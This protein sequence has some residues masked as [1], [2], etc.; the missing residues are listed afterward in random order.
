VAAVGSRQVANVVSEDLLMLTMFQYCLIYILCALL[1]GWVL[2]TASERNRRMV[3]VAVLA[4]VVVLLPLALLDYTSQA[5][6][7][8]PLHTYLLISTFPAVGSATVLSYLPQSGPS[9]VSR[10]LLSS[11]VWLV[12]VFAT[13]FTGFYP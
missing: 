4:C 8:T 12:L 3:W 2:G 10:K 13:L 6:K 9:G 5:N 11:V 1:V 7:E